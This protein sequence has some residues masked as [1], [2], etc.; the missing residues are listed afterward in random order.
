MKRDYLLYLHDII[1]SD[2]E[3]PVI[4]KKQLFIIK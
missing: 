2:G 4:Y 3:H 1:K